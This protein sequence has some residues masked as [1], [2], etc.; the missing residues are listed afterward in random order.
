MEKVIF[1]YENNS[2]V[3]K[4]LDSDKLGEKLS[5]T[6]KNRIENARKIREL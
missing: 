3:F 1:I 6:K 5:G 2:L 4:K